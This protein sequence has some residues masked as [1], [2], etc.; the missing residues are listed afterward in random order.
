MG[1]CSIYS[2]CTKSRVTSQTTERTASGKKKARG[3]GREDPVPS[4]PFFHW[5]FFTP[6]PLTEHL[7]QA[8]KGFLHLLHTVID[9]C[10]SNSSE[11]LNR[12]KRNVSCNHDHPSITKFSWNHH[13][14]GITEIFMKSRLP[15]YQW[16][17][18]KNLDH[19]P[20]ITEIF[21]KLEPPGIAESFRKSQPPR[22]HGKQA[23]Q[24][25]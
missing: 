12:S 18:P 21:I 20:S 25:T 1:S 17:F 23:K 8:K 7:K 19:P 11:T 3:L 4:S 16:N 6:L 15:R 24:N 22:Y 13:H 5:L 9:F 10:N 2:C 14:L